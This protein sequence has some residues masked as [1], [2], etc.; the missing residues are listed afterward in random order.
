MH[1]YYVKCSVIKSIV[2][3]FNTYMVK[4]KF[5][6]EV[7]T[8]MIVKTIEL[9]RQVFNVILLLGYEIPIESSESQVTF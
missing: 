1:F 8:V 5:Y 3:E 9:I 2:Y 7:S 4:I 6:I